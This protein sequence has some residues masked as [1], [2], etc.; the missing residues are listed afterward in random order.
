M[1][2]HYFLTTKRI[3]FSL[4]HKDDIELARSLWGDSQVTK[5]I[6]ATGIFSENDIY[7]RLCKEIENNEK[8]QVQYWP[9]FEL[10]SGSFIGC[11]GLRPYEDIYE[12]GIHIKPEFWHKGY[13]YE[14]IC[15]VKDYAFEVLD[16]SCLFAGHNPYNLASKRLLKK[17][18]FIYKGDEY[19]EPTGLYHPSYILEKEFNNVI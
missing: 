18:G 12:I 16:I 6:C 5:Y 1:K 2:R 14:A 11:C 9:I 7:N 13:G 15:E 19:Y 8:Y 3:G 17:V 10:D 4:W